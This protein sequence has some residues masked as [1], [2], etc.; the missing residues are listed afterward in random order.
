MEKKGKILVVDD[1]KDILL[2]ARIVL[3]KEFE[4]IRTTDK[5]EDIP[6]ILQDT[7][8][9]VVLLDMN[10]SS[11]ATS[12]REGIIWLRKLHEL[13]NSINVIMITAYGEIDL[14]VKAMKEGA[15]DF[16]VIF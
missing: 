9:D 6:G 10:F 14:A 13:D 3:K 4:L 15:V 11:G 7:S 16:I 1:D 12:G 2:T 8:V 5:P